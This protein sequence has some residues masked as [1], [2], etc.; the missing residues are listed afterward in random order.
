MDAG[1]VVPNQNDVW[2]AFK[3]IWRESE[4]WWRDSV[5]IPPG[6]VLDAVYAAVRPSG[7]CFDEVTG[8]LSMTFGEELRVAIGLAS[9]EARP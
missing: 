7:P 3:E 4:F 5:L 1:A 9:D 2:N 6:R 8:P